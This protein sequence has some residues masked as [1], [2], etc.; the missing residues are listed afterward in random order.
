[1]LS[2]SVAINKVWSVKPVYITGPTGKTK[3]FIEKVE[4]G[5]WKRTP[6]LH[7]DL[8]LPHLTLSLRF[9]LNISNK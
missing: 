3:D 8:Q 9:D 6:K 4:D 5:F 2:I 7:K 1:M